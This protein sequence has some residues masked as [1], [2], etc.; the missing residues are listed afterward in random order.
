MVDIDLKATSSEIETTQLDCVPTEEII[1][2]P[3]PFTDRL[4]ISI[5]SAEELTYTIEI[6]DVTGRV[7]LS[8][9]TM[10]GTQTK[11]VQLDMSSFSSS[12]YFV[13]VSS[14]ELT[15]TFKVNKLK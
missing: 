2:S 1:V 14:Y 15:Q 7:V 4:Q 8:T 3:N 6:I 12:T 13:R 9:Q 5:H 10:V 11:V